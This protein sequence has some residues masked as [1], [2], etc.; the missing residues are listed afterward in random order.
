[1]PEGRVSIRQ[2]KGQFSN[3]FAGAIPEGAAQIQI[4]HSTERLGA[5]IVRKGL[6]RMTCTGGEAFESS[7]IIALYRY[8]TKTGRDVI[9]Y[10]MAN[11]K[12]CGADTLTTV[13]DATANLG[14][15]S[16]S[17]GWNV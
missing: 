16:L 5:L 14:A 3:G 12:F 7:Q 2:F 4:N 1:M 11:G 9:V 10:E 6:R 17:T 15:A 13:A 8:Q